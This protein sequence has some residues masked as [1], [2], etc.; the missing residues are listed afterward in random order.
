MRMDLQDLSYTQTL[1]K[2]YIHGSAE[3]IGLMCLKIFC[4]GDERQYKKLEAGAQGVGCRI[5]KS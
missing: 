3:V 2:K 1:Y 4:N 5:P